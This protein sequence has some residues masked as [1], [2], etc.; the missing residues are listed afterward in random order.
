MIGEESILHVDMDAFFAS[1]E[2]RDNPELRGKPVIVAGLGNRGVVTAASYEA[3]RYGVHSAMPTLRA[4]RLCPDGI[5]LSPHGPRYHE[6][7]EAIRL[8]FE[9]FTPLVESVSLDEA[10]LDVRGVG[11]LFGDAVTVGRAIRGRIARDRRLPASVGIG[12]SKL[13]AKLASRAA[14]PDGLVFVPAGTET[15]FLWPRPVSALWGV[16][17]ATLE[18]L[19]R[20]GIRTVGDLAGVPLPSLERVLGGVHG[21]HLHALAHAHD[22]SP[23]TTDRA[24]KSIGHEQTFPVDLSDP[25]T[26][27]TELLRLSDRVSRRLRR[28]GCSARTITLKCRLATFRTLTRSTTM[29]E[30]VDATP[31]IHAAVVESLAKLRLGHPAIRLLGVSASGLRVGSPIRQLSFESRPHWQAVMRATDRVRDRWGED[32]VRPARLLPGGEA[33]T[34]DHLEVRRSGI[35]GFSRGPVEI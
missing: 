18:L 9:A 23:V 3:R 13:I 10:F 17:K 14:K 22:P 27:H 8:I 32:A 1:V 26:I 28:S 12:T 24:P 19:D 34:A 35:A 11:R 21:R 31:E 20:L 16:G 6:E 7:S 30:P 29:Q 2:I 5:F 4:R 33:A 15:D 25:E